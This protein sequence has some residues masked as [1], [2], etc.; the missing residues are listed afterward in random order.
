MALRYSPLA[1]ALGLAFSG[2]AWAQQ[3]SEVVL[4]EVQVRSDRQPDSGYNPPTATSAT[5][6]EA[7]LRDIP[8][9]VNVVPQ[10]LLRDQVAQSMQDA[11]K[12]VPGV[13]FSHGDGQRDQVTIRGFSAIADQF[14][15]GLRD[16]ALYFRD[17][18]NIEQIEV[19]KGPASVLYGRGSS[20]G[21]INRITKKPGVN[22]SELG[23]TLGRWNQRRG[24]FDLARAPQDSAVSYRLTGAVERADS[25]RDRQ[26]LDRKALAASV[27]IKPSADTSVLLQADYLKDS[28]LT[29][30]GI[31]AYQGR[32]VNVSPGTYYG[33]ANA[34]D[35]DVSRAEVASLGA[36]LNHRISDSLS[37][38][39]A[40]RYY[41][42][43]L[44]RNN[45][46]VGSV[47]EKAMT[48]SLTRGNVQRDES[49]FFNQTELSQKLEF[50]GMKHQLLYGFEFGRQSKDLLSYSRANVAT[51]SLFNPVLPTLPLRI[52]GKP[53]A[54]NH[55]VF[56]VASAYLQDLVTISPQ[57]KA[58]AGVR[59]DRFL[60]ETHERQPGKP[61]LSRTDT[62]W[63]PRVG[64]V[65]QP[66]SA[67]SYYASWSKSFQPSGETFALAA[68]NAQ[69]APEKTTSQEVGVKWD[70]P[71]GKASVTASLFKLERT[72]IKSV[73]PTSNTV[74]PLGVQRT[75]GLELTFAG[76]IAPTWQVWAGYAFLD[77]E[78]TTSPAVDSGQP[79]QGKRP[80]LTPR[81]SA[82]LWVTKA[83]GHGFGLGGGL[84][85]VGAR[86]ANPGNTVTLP[87]YTTV[88][89]MAYY[90]MGPWDVQLK[91]NNLLNRR[92][93]VAGHGSSPNLNLPGAPRSAQVV[94]R[95]RF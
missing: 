25:Y 77:G 79:V 6:I 29:D 69:L 42:Y 83:L 68:N 76:E 16:D 74:V 7:P 27:L 17:L 55:S 37:L 61:D 86:F 84:N 73:D 64:L 89:A 40:L 36:T 33:A 94:A 30:F 18:S 75:N 70:L 2:A 22:L 13:G 90:R 35:V 91:L 57:W 92:Y 5:K 28:R 81:Q 19:L 3:A 87:G 71:D 14:V 15:D 49:G 4:E 66:S 31:P 82:N 54:D 56:K 67:W 93:I 8:Q 78:M 26:F 34:R 43:S 38:R 95:Y 72:N 48:A 20:G 85:Y 39:N 53:A 80:T 9:T 32:P 60:Q 1:A 21:L 44:D 47:N 45:T 12:A 11:L 23:L 50:A 59:Y 46:L 65:Y 58:L 62:A 51:V 10:S 52:D 63:S 24:E 88:D 41:D